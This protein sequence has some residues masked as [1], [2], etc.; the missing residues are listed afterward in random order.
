MNRPCRMNERLLFFAPVSPQ[1]LLPGVAGV[2]WVL[3]S[4]FPH[5]ALKWA[6]RNWSIAFPPASRPLL[7]GYATVPGKKIF[8]YIPIPVKGDKR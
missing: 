3:S 5:A 6:K 4:R 1:V 8:H 2:V 7:T